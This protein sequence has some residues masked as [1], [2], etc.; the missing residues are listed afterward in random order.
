METDFEECRL[1]MV[2]DRDLKWT[3]LNVVMNLGFHRE[4]G[5]T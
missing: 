1:N 2:Q 5:I 4:W 3:L